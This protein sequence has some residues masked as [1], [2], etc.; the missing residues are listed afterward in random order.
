MLL[1]GTV[2]RDVTSM[3]FQN[4]LLAP[5][6]VV[7]RLSGLV[8]RHDNWTR[9]AQRMWADFLMSR[10]AST[11]LT[12]S[13]FTRRMSGV[14]V[15]RRPPLCF[16]SDSVLFLPTIGTRLLANISL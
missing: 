2:Q 11:A 1:P 16:N 6:A 14:R 15:P 7:K 4:W 3:R 5:S 12:P 9:F 10:Q 13:C 8:Q